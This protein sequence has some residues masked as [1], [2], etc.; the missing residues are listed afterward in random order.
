MLNTGDRPHG[1]THVRSAQPFFLAVL[2][3]GDQLF[4]CGML[5]NEFATLPVAVQ[6]EVKGFFIRN[7][8]WLTAILKAGSKSGQ[9]VP[10]ADPKSAARSFFAVLEGALISARTFGDEKRLIDAGNWFINSLVIR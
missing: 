5:A 8:E 6:N 1:M 9:V 10:L 4:F 7:E 2:R 3:E